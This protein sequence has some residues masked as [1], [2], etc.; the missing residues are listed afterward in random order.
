MNTAARDRALLP[1]VKE[2]LRDEGNRRTPISKLKLSKEKDGTLKVALHTSRPNNIRM[3]AADIT[4]AVRERIGGDRTVQVLVVPEARAVA[5]YVRTSPRKARLVADVIKG[6]RVSDAIAMLRFIPN[7]AAEL[8]SKVLISAAAN[9]LD[10]WG[11]G[12]EE[13]KVHNVIADGGPSLKRVRARA[14]GRAYR[15][16]KRT[17]HITVIL[18]EA[19]APAPR[20]R[21]AAPARPKAA[22]RAAA[23]VAVAEEVTAPV[24]AEETTPEIVA[25]AETAEPVETA[26]AAASEPVEA[27]PVTASD[28]PEEDTS[29]SQPDTSAG[30]DQLREEGE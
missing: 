6:K 13:L 7:R 30:A 2:A 10:G 8:I 26:P 16:V 9:A 12:V 21:R 11:A 18:S 22:V 1:T 14:Q 19:P 29:D 17:S 27:T 25:V 3:R 5:K 15:I 24:V 20:S 28:A 23:P 4:E